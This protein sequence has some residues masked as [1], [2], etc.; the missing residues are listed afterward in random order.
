MLVEID[1]FFK[2]LSKHN[3]KCS[4]EKQYSQQCSYQSTSMQT[5]N[6]NCKKC[7]NSWNYMGTEICVKWIF[8]SCD[9][10]ANTFIAMGSDSRT[11]KD[12]K[13]G[14]LNLCILWTMV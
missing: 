12:F 10:I 6:S 5:L 13:L 1:N 2:P 14:H 7:Y 8:K 4:N 11:A 9:D 3:E